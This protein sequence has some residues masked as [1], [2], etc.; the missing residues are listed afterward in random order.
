MPVATI[1]VLFRKTVS[2]EQLSQ[3]GEVIER[4]DGYAVKIPAG[5][6]YKGDDETFVYEFRSI[7]LSKGLDFGDVIAIEWDKAEY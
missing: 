1:P 2:I 4:D 3:L 5:M 7:L 6:R